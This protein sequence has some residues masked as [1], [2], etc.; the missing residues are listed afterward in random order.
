MPSSLH[1]PSWPHRKLASPFEPTELAL[2]YTVT[3]PAREGGLHLCAR[4]VPQSYSRRVVSSSKLFGSPFSPGC[5]SGRLGEQRRGG[6]GAVR[7]CDEAR[8]SNG[9]RRSEDH[10]ERRPRLVVTQPDRHHTPLPRGDGMVG[11]PVSCFCG[12]LVCESTF[13]LFPKDIILNDR[14]RSTQ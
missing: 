11:A 14:C 3:L 5:G 6:R 4:R 13:F 2:Y 8:R 7:S 9:L 12:V 10:R 1:S